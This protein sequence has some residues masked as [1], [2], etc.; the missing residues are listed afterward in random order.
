MVYSG[1]VADRVIVPT[2]N[3]IPGVYILKI[4]NAQKVEVSRIVK[5]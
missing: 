3:F 4:R 5:N 1:T 2:G